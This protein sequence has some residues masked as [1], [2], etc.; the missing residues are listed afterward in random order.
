MEKQTDK[1]GT[2]GPAI[3]HSQGQQ[4]AVLNRFAT[5]PLRCGLELAAFDVP[6]PSLGP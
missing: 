4:D 2:H 5:T 1:V 3:W 6:N